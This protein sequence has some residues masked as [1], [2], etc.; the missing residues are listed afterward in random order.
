MSKNVQ[1]KAALGIY[2]IPEIQRQ[3]NFE[4]DLVKSNIA[5]FGSSMSGKTN[6]VKLLINCLH[7]KCNDKTEQIFILDFSGA[8]RDYENLPLVSAYY[9]NS[10]EE[11][12]KRIFKIIETILKNNIKSLGSSNFQSGEVKN[13]LHTTF[14]I[15]NLNAFVDEER[16]SAYHEKFARLARD[17]R[18]RGISIVFTATDTKGIGR[19]LLSFEQKIVLNM[20]P[21]KCSEIFG[22]KVDEIAM[23][24]GRGYANVTE[25]L[26]NVTGTFNMNKPYEVQILLADAIK[27]SDFLQRVHE[28]FDFKEEK[29]KKQVQKYVRF[30]QELIYTKFEDRL[31]N[32]DVQSTKNTDGVPCKKF[33][34]ECPFVKAPSNK[35]VP[36]SNMQFAPSVCVGLDYV[37]FKPVKVDFENSR[38]IAIYGKKEYGKT[39]LLNVLLSEIMGQRP[40]YQIVLFDDGRNQLSDLYSRYEGKIVGGRRIFQFE[41]INKMKLSPIQQ[42]YKLIH[43]KYINL[44]PAGDG[45]D[46]N[47]RKIYPNDY[48]YAGEGYDGNC[49]GKKPT[50]FVIQSK[51]MYTYVKYGIAESFI[52]NI[53][54]QLVD[55][56]EDEDYIF[57]FSDVQKI[58]DIN[59]REV[60]N[61][62]IKVAFLLDNIADFVSDRGKT[63]VF[64]D[65]DAKELKEEYANCEL[66]DGY[67]YNVEADSLKKVKFIKFD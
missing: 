49:D 8:L 10:N 55:L 25:K 3:D 50:V 29:Y 51:S 67:F 64:G 38:V 15:E 28:K 65:R 31:Q 12:V 7:K 57:I 16:Y 14:I 41:H 33:C 40:D 1:I 17:G 21:D 11:Y 19:Y 13:L 35:P 34:K 43:E 52:T 5:V 47:L 20:S 4:I 42:F 37:E 48:D 53:L 9:D 46:D 62:T 23:T 24:A 36:N 44:D 45:Y 60:F 58:T 59:M 66:G 54:P 39:N 56:A 6:L 61:S 63:S 32:N 22:T 26:K 2:D 18:S 30:P 27:D